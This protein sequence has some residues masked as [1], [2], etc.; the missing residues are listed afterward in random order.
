MTKLLIILLFL[1]GCSPTEPEDVYGCTDATACN[2]NSDANIFDNSCFYP[3]DWEDECGVCDL[4]TSNDCVQDCTGDWGGNAVVID[5]CGNCEG[6]DLEWVEL[7]GFCHNIEETTY[8]I[9]DNLGLGFI[10]DIPQEIPSEIGSLINLKILNL[11]ANFISGEIPLEIGNLTDLETL[12]LNSNFLSGQIP[13]EI[14]NLINLEELLLSFNEL[15]GEI[16]QEVC[17]LIES[18]DLNMNYITDGN[19]L[20]NT[21]N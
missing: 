3:E 6:Q 11:D 9:L 7:W 20:I 2:F 14:G 4:D 1:F 12:N 16:P 5:E 18:N 8:L 15:T 21:C 13:S 10:E 17:D 19:N